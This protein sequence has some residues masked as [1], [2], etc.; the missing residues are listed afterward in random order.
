M[1][2]FFINN[3]FD[4]G[5]T[6]ITMTPSFSPCQSG[7]KMY[8]LTLKSLFEIWKFDLRSGHV[9]VRS[10]SYHDP[11]RSICTPE[12]ARLAKSFGTICASPSPSCHDL[13]AKNGLWRHLTSGG[14]LVSPIVSCT[15]ICTAG[16][17]GHASEINGWFWLAYAKREEFSYFP[18]GL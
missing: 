5:D 16:V 13:L 2:M 12:A 18:I 4:M 6:T 14:L 10:R 15:Q 7:S 8:F 3:F 9:K 11:S 17:S 1:E